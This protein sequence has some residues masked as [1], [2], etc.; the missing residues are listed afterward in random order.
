MFGRWNGILEIAAAPP[1]RTCDTIG[2][3]R[4]VRLTDPEL[5]ADPTDP[6]AFRARRDRIGPKVGAE[7]TGASLY[8]MDPGQA[9]CPY[10]YEHAEEEWLL[11]V[12]GHPSVRTPEGVTRL[13]PHDLV[14][15][16]TGPE[17]AH[18]ILNGSDEPARVLMWSTVVHPAVTVYPDSGKIGVYTRDRADDIVVRRESGVDYYEGEPG[19]P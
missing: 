18:Q 12:S 14:F 5:V 2:R 19:P 13:D 8:E 4:R 9:V 16:P 17:G 15:F 1:V 10:H 11:V 6:P 7:R 3:M